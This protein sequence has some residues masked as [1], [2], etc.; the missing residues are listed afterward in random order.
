MLR[1][2]QLLLAVTLFLLA[3]AWSTAQSL[4][5]KE[6]DARLET[7]L[8]DVLK[9][10]TDIYN[11]GS[12]D[13][14]YRL[15]QGS[16]MSIVGFLE[17]RPDQ[18]IKINKAIKDTNDMTSASERAFTL[19]KALDDL[20]AAIK[21]SLTSQMNT[22]PPDNSTPGQKKLWDRLGG[23]LT[24]T[25]L[26]EDLVTRV[27]KNPKINF[28]RRGTGNQWDANPEN[29]SKIKKQFMQWI[30]SVSGGPFKYEARDM[31]TVHQKMKISEAEYDFFI[32]ELKASLNKY[33]VS[34]EAVAELMKQFETVKKDIV[35]S[36]IVVK[37]LWDRL[38][39]EA[40]VT[41][42]VDDFV[43]RVARNAAVNFTR[44]NEGRE[45]PGTPA[46]VTALRKQLV[47]WVSSVANGPL[48]YTGK[49]M[50]DAHTGMKISNAQFTAIVLDLKA[51]LDL[52][53]ISQ[54]EQDELLA[55][56]SG[57]RT[58]IVEVK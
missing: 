45:W 14:C 17:H 7:Q 49:S 35:D 28:A 3:P 48:K 27:M 13:A 36:T 56:V 33:F 10:G 42:L 52:C 38:G 29:L 4:S 16:L 55:I 30:S 43:S 47:Q 25:L 22:T 20:R 53:K 54:A 58:D 34:P 26:V 21:P 12:Q 11:R 50:K 5:P 24:V 6:I 46:E 31:K 9:L 2:P 57:L 40:M 32:I 44:K 1:T 15:Y 41:L 18:I 23:E 51:S 37:S 19:R 39:G 8:Y